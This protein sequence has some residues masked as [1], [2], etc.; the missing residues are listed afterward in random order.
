MRCAALA[1][2]FLAAPLAA[3]VETPP[4]PVTDPKSL[5]S[6]VD[7]AARPVPIP[8]LVSSLGIRSATWSSDGRQIFLSTNLTG[9]FNVW[10]VDAVGSWPV[11]MT[12]SDDAQSGLAVSPDGKTLYFQQD[13]GGDEYYDLYAVPTAGGPVAQLT[14]TPDIREAGALVGPDGRIAITVKKKSA[15]QT[16]LAILDPATK[17]VRALTHETV[18]QWQW[19]AVAWIDAGKVLVANRSSVDRTASEVWRIDATSGEAT[20][21]IGK[22]GTFY[23]ASDA[24]ADGAAVAVT[25]N[26]GTGQHHAVVFAAGKMRTLRP[27]PWEQS[28]EAFTPDGKSMLVLTNYDGRVVLTLADVATLAERPIVLPP[29]IN[30]PIGRR[31]FTADGRLLVEHSGA[32][33]PTEMVSADIRRGV[34]T[35]VTHLAPA[36]LAPE[37]LPKSQ[38]VTHKSFDGTLISAIVTMPFNLKRDGRNPAVVL[39]H[40]GPTGQAVDGFQRLAT[41][42]ASRGYVVIQ[43]N[44]RGSTGYGLAFQKANFQ[45]LGGGDL[46]DEIAGK[47]F[48]VASGYVDPKR[49]GITGGSYGGYMTLMAIGRTPEAF[50]AAVEMYGIIDWRTMWEHE[51]SLLQAYQRT[52][53]GA[54]DEAPAVYDATSPITYIKDVKAPLL[55]LQGEN[56]IRVP[57]GQARQVVEALKAKGNVIDSVFYP[58][59]GHGFLKRENQLD[60][61]QRTV[62]WF[63]KHLKVT[64]SP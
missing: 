3:Q 9:R 43:P 59:E 39:P 11:Q 61:L 54:P 28:S 10:R 64:S 35:Q 1:G 5:V 19:S 47:D 25:T 20:R 49:V 33:T 44:P 62:A 15:G 50:A 40:G 27:T 17:T 29:G 13:Q 14:D 42:F 23:A 34:V 52:M 22:E 58:A 57:A 31:P 36:S 18:P 21:L 51:D 60:S 12:Q 16:D 2:L 56:D 37:H 41:A 48:L 6:P 8:D 24:T 38:V 46:K 63:D 26:E 53:L 4:R 30:T 32:D 7:A 45:D 55:V